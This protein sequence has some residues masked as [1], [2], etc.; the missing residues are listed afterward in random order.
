MEDPDKSNING[1]NTCGKFRE[2]YRKHVQNQVSRDLADTL[3]MLNH[4]KGELA[5]LQD[6]LQQARLQVIQSAGETEENINSTFKSLLINVNRMITERHHQL[7]DEVKQVEVEAL[8][9]LDECGQLLSD[10][11]KDCTN[12]LEQGNRLQQSTG[13]K[14]KESVIRFQEETSQLNRLPDV[15]ELCAVPC[16]SVE[17]PSEPT[18]EESLQNLIQGAGKVSRIGPVQITHINERPGALLVAWE[19][20]DEDVGDDSIEFCLQCSNT[21][22][23]NPETAKFHTVYK[24]PDFSFLLRNLQAGERYLLRAALRREGSSSWSTWSLPQ[25]AQTSIPHYKWAKVDGWSVADDGRLAT[26]SSADS[27]ILLSHGPLLGPGSSVLFK[28]LGSGDSCSDEGIGLSCRPVKGTE[29]LLLP[30]VLFLNAQGSLVEESIS[31]I[32]KSHILASVKGLSFPSKQ[33]T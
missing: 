5:K 19:E 29:Q 24:G 2:E 4:H 32:L 23:M 26:K 20:V 16:V 9:P 13:T 14:A 30:G 1:G 7:L 22:A 15:P 33:S 17:F 10:R 27:D 25:Y 6:Q 11:L 21:G 18:L 3:N 28:V 31:K 12:R 8:G